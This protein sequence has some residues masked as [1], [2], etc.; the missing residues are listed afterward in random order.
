MKITVAVFVLVQILQ[1][2][3][4][5]NMV[6]ECYDKHEKCGEWAKTGECKT[7]P[8][9]MSPNCMKSCGQCSAIGGEIDVTEDCSKWAKDGECEINFDWMFFNC[10]KACARTGKKLSAW[11]S[12]A[13]VGTEL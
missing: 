5:G 6:S 11:R 1:T 10:P 13:A 12:G 2:Q 4:K 3:A 7:N 8:T 9:W